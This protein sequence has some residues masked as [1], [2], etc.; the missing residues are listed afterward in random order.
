VIVQIGGIFRTG[1]NIENRAFHGTGQDVGECKILPDA[2]KKFSET[3]VRLSDAPAARYKNLSGLFLA[4]IKRALLRWGKLLSSVAVGKA[5]RK[6]L[7]RN[8]WQ[9]MCAGEYHLAR[10]YRS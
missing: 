3:A 2:E 7:L 4:G 5:Q 10:R 9:H 1:M 6:G 8:D